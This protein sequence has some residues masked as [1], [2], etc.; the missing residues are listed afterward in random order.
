[1]RSLKVIVLFLFVFSLCS[2]SQSVPRTSG[3]EKETSVADTEPCNDHISI[4]DDVQD[5]QERILIRDKVIRPLTKRIYESWLKNMPKDVYPPIS[6]KGM[7]AVTFQL[8]ADGSIKDVVVTK[9]AENELLN[10]AA[11]D[12][13]LFSHHETSGRRR[14]YPPPDEPAE[15]FPPEL[16]RPSL[17]M[18]LRFLYNTKCSDAK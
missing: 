1:M 8:M 4:L 7:V 11:R 13:I 9:A 17:H 5:E 6:A 2:L 12:A 3:N 14:L 15:S 10:Q 18:R 16:H